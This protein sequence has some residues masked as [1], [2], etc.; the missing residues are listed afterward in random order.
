MVHEMKYLISAEMKMVLA[1][2][3]LIFL[4][5]TASAQ[6]G[7][8]QKK[9]TR[10]DTLRGSVTPEREWWDALHYDLHV[11]FDYTDSTMK[12]YNAIQYKVQKTARRMQIDL[13]RPLVMDSLIQDGSTLNYERD[14]NA[15]FVD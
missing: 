5:A 15:F 12:G 6:L 7:T 13:M 4:L 11:R 1:T 2:I 14:G 3:A 10:A 8:Q 9:Y